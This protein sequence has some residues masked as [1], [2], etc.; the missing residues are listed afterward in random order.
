[1]NAVPAADR[2]GPGPAEA[3]PE[4]HE[5]RLGVGALADLS[6]GEARVRERFGGAG[7]S[8]ER[9]AGAAGVHPSAGSRPRPGAPPRAFGPPQPGEPVPARAGCR[10]SAARPP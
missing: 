3:L 1:M 8:V 7:V 9:P 4:V 10:P 6:L 2:G 5:V